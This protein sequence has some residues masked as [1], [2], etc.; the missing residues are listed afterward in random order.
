MKQIFS[1][2]IASL[3]ALSAFAQKNDGTTKSLVNAEKDFAKSIAKNGDKESYLEYSLGSAL[4]FRPNPV[5]VK[6]FY[7]TQTKGE[8]SV[9]WEPNL[10]KVSRSGDLGFTTG[11]YSVNGEE[12]QYGQYLSIWKS[13]NGKWKLAIDLET[14]S[15]KPLDQTAPRFVEPKDHVAPK[16]LNEREI[17]AGREIILTT[18]KT[19]NTFLKTHGIGAFGG[20]M[21]DDSRLL[22]PGNEAITGKG[23]ILSF[24]NGMISK[25]NLKTTGVDKALGSDLA[26]TFGVATIDYKADLRESFNYVFVYEKAADASWNL[27]V[28]AFVP[29]ER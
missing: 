25:I 3:L 7:N 17:K 8:K 10:A 6:T 28:Q 9:T 13:E 20:F 21:T 27:V 4:V 22:F 24:Y 14:S 2:A 12:K 23:K 19:L 11:P 15:N 5:N 29:A 26:Y 1:T 18:E 16:F